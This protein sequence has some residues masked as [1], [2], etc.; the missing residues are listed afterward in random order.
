MMR[1]SN[2]LFPFT[3]TWAMSSFSG[4]PIPAHIRSSQFTVLLAN[5]CFRI[6][7]HAVN[8]WE[9]GFI[10]FYFMYM[11]FYVCVFI[12]I[13]RSGDMDP[14][15]FHTILPFHLFGMAMGLPL[16]II[17]IRDIYLRS[18]P[19]PNTKVTWTI[20]VLVFWPAI[21]AYLYKHGFH[22]RVP[23]PLHQLPGE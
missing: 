9:K 3:Q 5:S 20:L 17:V 10:V 8:R 1:V 16:Y 2:R 22:P 21:I 13:I 14:A 11:I 15:T 23:R 4:N 6:A 7:S 19:N 12:G 18:F